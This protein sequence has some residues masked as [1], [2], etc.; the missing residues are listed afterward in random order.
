MAWRDIHEE[1]FGR[2]PNGE[3]IALDIGGKN[4]NLDMKIASSQFE[5]NVSDVKLSLPAMHFKSPTFNNVNIDSSGPKYR[6]LDYL[7][8]I[9]IDDIPSEED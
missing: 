8:D 1:Q 5:T 9:D 3:L 4:L 7:Y 6:S 2:R